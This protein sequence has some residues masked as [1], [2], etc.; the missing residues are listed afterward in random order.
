ME[1]TL[2]KEVHFPL[3][4]VILL[5]AGL[6]LLIT[7]ILLFPVSMGI[8][9][10]YENGLYGLFL[11]LF[12]LQT[13]GLG[14]TPFGDAPRSNV[15]VA[16]GIFI[17]GIGV[18]TCFIPG[19][20]GPIPAILLF[21][22][23]SLGG[24]SLLLQLFLDKEKYKNW[25]KYGGIFNHLIAGCG[26]VYILS[27]L[28]GLLVI[29]PSLITT[30]MVAVLVFIYGIAVIYLA[31]ILKSIYHKYPEAETS[32]KGS[33][34]LSTDKVLILLLS[35]LMLILGLL[36]IPVCLGRIPFAPNAQLG[37]LM[38]IFAIQM[39]ALG[40]TPVGPF[41]RN[42]LM[43]LLGLLFA[44]LGIVSIIIPGI[45]VGR[46]T[47]LVGLLNISGGIVSLWKTLTP[48][49]QKREKTQ[50]PS[51]PILTKLFITQLTLGLLSVLFGTS[52]LVSNLLP[53]II[54]GIILTAN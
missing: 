28:I 46:L 24:L 41:P 18:I 47:I 25:I 7:G 33:A 1:D 4:V 14:K 42:W 49:F 10:Y 17:A 48:H 31:S 9:P 27:I 35:V 43:F 45:L 51:H 44:S 53:G 22:C 52:M 13:I 11:V 20:L 50:E 6:A 37:L 16:F 15:V 23:F 8:L 5:I 3:E 2:L 19:I 26:S 32:S 21:I 39:M 29:K 40:N 38:T 30:K 36:L 54:V 34:G 12:A